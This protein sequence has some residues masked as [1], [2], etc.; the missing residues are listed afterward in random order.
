MHI[1]RLYP[2]ISKTIEHMNCQVSVSKY[3]D[4]S[5]MALSLSLGS[6]WTTP[7]RFFPDSMVLGKKVGG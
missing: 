3:L 2:V 7:S 5:Y 6:T 1:L 4:T